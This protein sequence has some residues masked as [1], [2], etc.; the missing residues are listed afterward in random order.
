MLISYFGR[1][2][3]VLIPDGVVAA[4]WGCFGSNTSVKTLTTP[5]TLKTLKKASLAWSSAEHVC[6]TGVETIEDSAFWGSKLESID[7]PDSLISVGDNAFGQCHYLKKLEFKNPGTVFQG[8]IAPMAY[9]LETVILPDGI[10]EIPDGAFYY[11]ESLCDIRIPE[12]VKHIAN[13]AFQ[14]CKSL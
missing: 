7:L 5:T 3:G 11:C 1:K 10:K 2:P 9:A 12:T 4:G 8:R 13:S 14:G 6:L